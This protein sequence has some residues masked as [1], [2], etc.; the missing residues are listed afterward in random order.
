MSLNT[1]EIASAGA[2]IPGAIKVANP[3]RP[4]APATG[5]P[6]D[7][8]RFAAMRL[9]ENRRNAAKDWL[10][11]RTWWRLF[12]KASFIAAFRHETGISANVGSDADARIAA[13]LPKSRGD[14]AG[15]VRNGAYYRAHAELFLIEM[16]RIVACVPGRSPEPDSG[17]AFENVLRFVRHVL[18]DSIALFEDWGARSAGVPGAF[19]AYKGE[20]QRLPE[21]F[22]G[23]KQIVYGHGSFGLSVMENHADL[24][25]GTIRQAVEIRLR[26]AF[27]L[28]GK[29]STVDGSFHPVALSELLDVV[30]DKRAVVTTP[31]PFENVVRVN[32][33]ANLLMHA[34][35]KHY[36]WSVP[37]VLEY[38]QPLLLGGGRVGRVWTMKSGVQVTRAAFDD[39]R[40]ELTSRVQ[41]FASPRTTSAFVIELAPAEACDVVFI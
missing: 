25:V 26:R 10:R 14:Y 18:F 4:K 3:A 36:A 15:K 27:G 19:G 38:L 8:Y 11:I 20:A 34:G 6:F 2:V 37:R 5:R 13:A 7:R 29:A 28:I 39:V 21:Y 40:A 16:D 17:F 35:L 1:N 32:S 24:A 30:M 41:A 12:G 23:A 33:W 31:M 9:C 22:H